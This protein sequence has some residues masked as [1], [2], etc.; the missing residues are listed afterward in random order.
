MA[1]YAL[2]HGGWH[3]AWCWERLIPELEA[4]GHSAIALD[5]PIEDSSATFDD[6]A[7][8][9]CAG[10]AE[11]PDTDLILVGHS[12]GGQSVPLVAMRRPLQHLVYL[13]G[14]P[15]IP[16]RPFLQ[17]MADESGMLDAGYTQGLGEKDSEGRRGWA[18]RELA[19]FH[20]Y[21]D[22]DER[23]VSSAFARL[24]RQSLSPYKVACSL[25]AYPDV[26][27]T[28][29]VC[30][31]DRMVNPDWSRSIAHDWLD[32]DVVEMPGSHSP[33]LSRPR[34]LAEVLDRLP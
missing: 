31:E 28:Y 10:T 32:A 21:G 7:E 22:C 25:T 5:L 11:V 26:D 9:V 24:R 2:V 30:V 14:V 29:V 3:G 19:R 23:T 8:V 1:T 18:D 33:F 16:G 6:Y 20:M 13:C 34:E 12:M 4:L 15:P 17:Q 27:T